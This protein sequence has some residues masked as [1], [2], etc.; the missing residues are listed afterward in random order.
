MDS[1]SFIEN[2]GEDLEEFTDFTADE[3]ISKAY[4][5][6]H[7]S[8]V[9]SRLAKTTYSRDYTLPDSPY[10][11]VTTFLESD[12]YQSNVFSYHKDTIFSG[13]LNGGKRGTFEYIILYNKKGPKY[14]GP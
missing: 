14:L 4:S 3:S 13:S 10:H 5:Y 12:I 9:S 7:S 6:C 2:Y 1:L 11:G 8:L